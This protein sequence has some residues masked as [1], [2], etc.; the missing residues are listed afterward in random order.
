[1]ENFSSL[2]TSD[3]LMNTNE[4]W[5]LKRK[6]FPKNKETLPFAKKDLSG[7]LITAQSQLNICILKDFLKD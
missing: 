7:N 2:T 1:M 5:N 6:A 3:G 4:M